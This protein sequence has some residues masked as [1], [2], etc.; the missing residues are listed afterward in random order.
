[1]KLFSFSTANSERFRKSRA[2][3]HV[4]LMNCFTKI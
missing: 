2:I 3:S 1:M 4:R